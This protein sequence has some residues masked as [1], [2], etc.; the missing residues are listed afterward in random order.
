[1]EG[2]DNLIRILI[3]LQNRADAQGVPAE[4]SWNA[5][6]N[7]LKN[8]SGIQMDYETFK[9]QYDKIP[10]MQNIVDRFDGDGIVL[11][12][13]EEPE[14]TQSGNKTTDLNVGAKRAANKLL[15]QPG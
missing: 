2:A 1:M 10:Q 15:Q 12:T 3:T 7:M 5:I 14:A 8:V 11:K 13:K 4:F 9:Q 6:S